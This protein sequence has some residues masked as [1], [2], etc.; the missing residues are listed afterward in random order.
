MYIDCSRHIIQFWDRIEW[1]D[2]WLGVEL[3]Y[4]FNESKLQ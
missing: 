4:E 3:A 1:E 2:V